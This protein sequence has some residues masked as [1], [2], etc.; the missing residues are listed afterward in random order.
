MIKSIAHLADIHIRTYRQHDEYKEV[1]D[2]LIKDLNLKFKN[3]EYLETRIVIVG[4]LFHQKITVSNEQIMLGSWFLNKLSEIARVIVVAG[5]HD[6]LENN[7]GRVDSITPIIKLIDNENVRYYTE[8]KCYLDDNIVWCNYSIFEE[9]ARPNIENSRI[10]NPDKK[11]IGLFHAPLIGAKTDIGYTFEVGE[12]LSHFEGCDFVLLGDIHKRQ[13]LEYE[14]IK[15]V[16]PGSLVQQNYGESVK[17]HGYLLWDVESENYEEVDIENN[18]LFMTFNIT[19]I[20][21]LKNEAEIL[22]NE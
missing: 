7:L 11:H 2:S 8:S 1:F 13:E 18:N 17:S 22:K 6:L 14:G 5:N 10:D 16:Y 9:N 20:E 3:F 4:D 15:L 12:S 19:S 21:D